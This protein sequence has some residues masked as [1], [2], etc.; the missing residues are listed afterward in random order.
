MLNSYELKM[1]KNFLDQ[2]GGKSVAISETYK[3]DLGV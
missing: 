3:N 1:L 2:K